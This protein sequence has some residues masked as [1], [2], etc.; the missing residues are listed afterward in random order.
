MAQE[1]HERLEWARIR[2]GHSSPRAAAEAFGWNPNTYKS[3]EQGLRGIP[4]QDEVRKYARAFGVSFV[5]LLSGEGSPDRLNVVPVMGRIGAAAEIMPEFEQVPDDGLFQIEAPFPVP[6]DAIA[7][8]VQGDSMWPRFDAGDVIICWREGRNIEEIVGWEAAVK[9]AD[10][11]RYLKRIL[12]GA[13][14]GTFDLESHNAQP[15]RGVKLEWA[16]EVGAIIRSHQWRKLDESSR[17]RVLKKAVAG[18]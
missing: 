5:W 1:F 3:R 6:D 15:I 2:A 11:K 12:R 7:F 13:E 4:D 8:E 14:K 18:R 17:K 10:G 9:T 16:A